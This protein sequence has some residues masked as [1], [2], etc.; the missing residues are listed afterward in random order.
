[1]NNLNM[2]N[3]MVVV[4]ENGLPTCISFM[5]DIKRKGIENNL[6]GWWWSSDK[7]LINDPSESDEFIVKAQ[8]IYDALT[9]KPVYVNGVRLF[10]KQ[11][12]VE[13]RTILDIHQTNLL[14]PPTDYPR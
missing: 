11:S 13:I 12:P 2:M 8:T 1:M 7:G 9:G 3:A 14:A 4:I 10:H 5:E 6:N